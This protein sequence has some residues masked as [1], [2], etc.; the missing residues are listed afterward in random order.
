MSRQD[1]WTTVEVP[2]GPKVEVSIFK[3]PGTNDTTYAI[4]IFVNGS[5]IYDRLVRGQV[6]PPESE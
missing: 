1:T 3:A 6:P 4:E 2:N 5:R